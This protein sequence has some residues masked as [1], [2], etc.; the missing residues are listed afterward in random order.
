MIITNKLHDIL[1]KVFNNQLSIEEAENLVKID[2][3]DK[4]DDFAQLDLYRQARTGIPEV[5]YSQSKNLKQILQITQKMIKK[6]NYAILTRVKSEHYEVLKSEFSKKRDC[7]FE[8][9]R[10]GRV[11]FIYD[12]QYKAPIKRGNV[13]VIT[14]GTSDIPIAEEVRIILDAIGV[15]VFPVYDVGIS[16]MH[17]IYP[18]LKDMLEKKVD[19]FI[20]IAGMEGTLPGVVSALVDKPVIGVPTSTGYGFGKQGE[21]ALTTMLQSCSPGLTVVNID[22]GFGAATF[23]ALIVFNK[24]PES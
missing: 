14:A 11:I 13:G 20:V 21:G 22:N 1:E 3:L 7:Q 9:N 15:G 12:N 5:I 4:L 6:N 19:V 16:G 8:G 23:A 24:Y 17:R 10:E 18:P 2:Y